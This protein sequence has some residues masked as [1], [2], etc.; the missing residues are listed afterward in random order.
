MTTFR[1]TVQAI[2]V[3]AAASSTS[4]AAV[5]GKSLVVSVRTADEAAEAAALDA[6]GVLLVAEDAAEGCEELRA[7]IEKHGRRRVTSENAAVNSSPFQPVLWSPRVL[8]LRSEHLRA[9]SNTMLT[10]VYTTLIRSF[11]G[12]WFDQGRHAHRDVAEGP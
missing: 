10:R 3:M 2:L 11:E 1:S 8:L 9:G 6:G 12:T 7:R 5:E 4:L